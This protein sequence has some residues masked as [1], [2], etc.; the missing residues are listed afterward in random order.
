M[1][2]TEESLAPGSYLIDEAGKH[3]LLEPGTYVVD[4]N[5]TLNEGIPPAI[6]WQPAIEN[7]KWE[8]VHK[9]VEGWGKRGTKERTYNIAGMY[10]LV[11]III[12]S[13]TWLSY[14]RIIEGQAIVGFLG[15][16]IGYL[17]SRGEIGL[18]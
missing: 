4:A 8:E 13:A 6:N 2:E 16:A 15:A 9:L 1:E 5:G 14:E 10:I 11:A 12:G 17:L 18:K 7:I 3:H